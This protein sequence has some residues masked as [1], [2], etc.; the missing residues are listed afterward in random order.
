MLTSKNLGVARRADDL[1]DGLLAAL[2]AATTHDDQG[3]ALGKIP[4]SLG[5]CVGSIF[6]TEF[7]N[8]HL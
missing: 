4:G 6:L 7:E 1:L 5:I 2:P 3:A 8:L